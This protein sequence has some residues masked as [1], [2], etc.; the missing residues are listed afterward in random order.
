GGQ[1]GDMQSIEL[2]LAMVA[3][4]IG[5]FIGL[6]A[7]SGTIKTAAGL[8][9]VAAILTLVSIPK[10]KPGMEGMIEVSLRVGF[11]GILVGSLAG[12]VLHWMRLK[13]IDKET[14]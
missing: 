3:L 6:N 4:G 1:K 14:S 2:L 13:A 12:C 7:S 5:L 8:G 9:A 10:V 11:Y